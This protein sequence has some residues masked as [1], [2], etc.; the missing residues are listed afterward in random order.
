MQ[1]KLSSLMLVVVLTPSSQTCGVSEPT[2]EPKG[3]SEPLTRRESH[4]SRD[5]EAELE[6]AVTHEVTEKL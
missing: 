6:L 2:S 3:Q 1:G 4:D 5:E